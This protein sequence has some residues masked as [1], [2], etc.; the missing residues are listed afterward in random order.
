MQPKPSPALT[1]LRPSDAAPGA[2]TAVFR[3]LE[4]VLRNDP[5]FQRTCNVLRAWNGAANDG[6]NPTLGE[7]PFCRIT[8]V[9]GTAGREDAA[10]QT[11][12]QSRIKYEFVVAGTNADDLDYLFTLFRAAIQQ[13]KV[14]SFNGAPTVFAYLKSLVPQDGSALNSYSFS[15]VAQGPGRL[16]DANADDNAPPATCM[17][18][19]GY[20]DLF[21]I[22]P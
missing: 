17:F 16:R 12:V 21:M 5:D 10:G 3:G 7:C 6:E 4:D 22:L 14:T 19:V 1:P 15:Q 11:R 20:V 9:T 2:L 18:A 13:E 8:P